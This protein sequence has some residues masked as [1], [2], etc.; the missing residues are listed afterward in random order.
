MALLES[1]RYVTWVPPMLISDVF[2]NGRSLMTVL[3]CVD[4]V[5][6]ACVADIIRIT[7]ITLKMVNNA[8]LDSKQGFAFFLLD[9][10]SDLSGCVHGMDILSNFVTQ[11]SKLSLHRIH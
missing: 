8:L 11:F 10:R 6:L 2:P 5:V 9:A 1:K 7:Q 4:T 3:H